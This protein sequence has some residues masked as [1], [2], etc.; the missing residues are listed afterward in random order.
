MD[1]ALRSWLAEVANETIAEVVALRDS[2][3]VRRVARVTFV[4]G[5][6]MI[7]K[8]LASSEIAEST[9]GPFLGNE[10]VALRALDRFLPGVAPS[11]VAVRTN[12]A[13]V[14]I[15]DLGTHPSLA[16]VLLDYDGER[17]T[18]VLVS[19][20]STLG[21]VHAAL[22]SRTVE[23]DA[24]RVEIGL[25]TRTL[26]FL[27]DV[28]E[29]WQLVRDALSGLGIDAPSGCDAEVEAIGAALRDPRWATLIH[30]DAC[31]DNTVANP[32][33]VF[34][35]ETAYV[36][37]ALL[38]AAYLWMPFPTCWCAGAIPASVL[39]ECDTEYRRAA[40]VGIPG[41]ADDGIY[42]T[43]LDDAIAAWF[44]QTSVW[45][46]QRSPDEDPSWGISTHRH[47]LSHRSRVVMDRGERFA[48]R[49]PALSTL[50]TRIAGAVASRW[51][52][53]AAGLDL[54]PAFT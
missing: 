27:G 1:E 29:R 54:Y 3:P 50:A 36:G 14:V 51:P 26:G 46:L 22:A 34:D 5:R 25:P 24:I 39:A 19:L 11:L 35:W 6:S 43:A 17:A 28:E 33:A 49:Y 48:V 23:I 8:Y 15:D 4:S 21:Q 18:T 2:H 10:A 16:K 9:E 38:D 47:R 13:C 42:S 31:P 37:H 7:A 52:E 32:F 44:V 53:A 12:P 41:V 45:S 30:G 20:A 40:A